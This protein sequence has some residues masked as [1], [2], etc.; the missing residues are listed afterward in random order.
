MR[1]TSWLSAFAK[2]IARRNVRM[3]PQ[4]RHCSSIRANLEQLEDRTLLSYNA[5][6]TNVA[7]TVVTFVGNS[8]GDTLTFTNNGAGLLQHNRFAEGDAGFNSAIDLDPNVGGDQTISIST[9]TSLVVQAGNGADTIQLNGLNLSSASVNLDGGGDNNDAIDVITAAV[10]IGGSAT[11]TGA[12]TID[13]NAALTAASL[14]MNATGNIAQTNAISVSGT[15]NITGATITLTQAN[16]LGAVT[17]NNGTGNVSLTEND[18]ISVA[19][20]THSG[21]VT[22]NAGTNA[23]TQTGAIEVGTGSLILTG[24]AITLADANNTVG[25]ITVNSGSGD[26]SLREDAAMSI[27]GITRT[28]G[29]IIL[30]AG[31]TLSQNGAIS[32]GTGTASLSGTTITLTQANV[33][34]AVT[35]NAGTGDVFL[36]ENA[37]ISLASVT[38][39]GNLTL[40]AG[41]NAI[42]QTGAIN[43]GTGTAN[44]TGGTITLTQAN[45]LGTVTI[46]AGS[47]NV[48]L[49]ENDAISLAAITHTGTLTLNAGT[50]GIT[51]TG[52]IG[53]GTGA[54]SL[55]GGVITL[56]DAAN[57]FG[58]I[59][60]ASGSGD[61]S[62]R[63]DAAM[64]VTGITRT[65]G[66]LTLN[67]NGGSSDLT[68]TGAISIATGTA[69][70]TA[71]NI[72]LSDAAN[73]F[74]AVRVIS[75][76]NVTLVNS[77]ATDI[78]T[79]TSTI[80]GT[81]NITSGGTLTDT[82][83]LVVTGTT[84]LSAGSG[85]DITLNNTSNNFS[86][87]V[88]NSGNNVT[89]RDTNALIVGTSTISGD[90]SVTTSGAITQ[91]G[92]IT[93]NVVGKTATFAAGAGN[94]ITL[95]N[96]SNEF[97]KVVITS[98]N[99]VSLR[100]DT[101]F[102]MGAAT[103]AGT[104]TLQSNG[105]I[106]QSGAFGST[107][108][109]VKL[110]SGTLTLS[111]TNTYSGTTTIT[112]GTLAL[113][114]ASN[115][116]IANTTSIDVG[117]GTI[118][119][120]T[121]LPSDRF[122]MASGQTLTGTGT[123]NGQLQPMS[124]SS[125]SPNGGAA[126]G[127]LNLSNG[128][129]TA[130]S[131]QSGSTFAVQVNGNVAGTSHD[132]LNVTG[133]VSLG[134][135]TLSTSGTVSSV[136][137]QVI[138]LIS[139]DGTDAVTGTFN[140]LAEGATVTIN[141][142]PFIISYAGGVGGNDVVL[143]QAGTATY[144]GT[145]VADTLELREATIAGQDFIQYY[146]G[147]VLTDQRL[148]ATVSAIQVDGGDGNDTLTLNYGGSG[149]FFSKA[150]TFNGQ[151]Q[152]STPGDALVISG[153]TFTTITNTLTSAND[154]TINLDG[155]LVTYTG[156]EPVL[157]NVGSAA[158]IVF[159]FPGAGNTAFLED[160][161]VAN[162]LSQLRSSP[163][164][165][166]TTTFV[167][168]TVSLTINMGAGADSLTITS[169][170]D[171]NASL[172]VDGGNATDSI[173]LSNN[174]TLGSATSNGNLS[175]T[176]ETIN[177]GASINTAAG[178]TGTHGNVTLSGSTAI[179]ATTGV[180]IDTNGAGTAGTLT[181]TGPISAAGQMLTLDV[182]SANNA[183]LNNAGNNFGTV[184]VTT[185][186]NVTLRDTNSIDLG[187]S[188]ISGTLSVTASGTITDS[189][190]VSVTGN[191]T[192]AAGAG[193]ITLGSGG[194]TTNY[195]SLTF[196]TTG[197]VTIQEDSQTDLSGTLTANSLTLTSSAAIVDAPGTSLTVTNGA[198]LT[199]TSIILANNG[200]DVLSV[201][202]TANFNGGA[203]DITIAGAGTVNLGNLT[204]NTTGGAVSV[205]EDSATV[206]TGTSTADSLTL[207]STGSIT[208]AVGTSIT[209]DAGAA[210]LT[211]TSISLAD[212]GT[213]VLSV[214][215]TGSFNGGAGAVTIAAAGT[216][217]FGSLT[218]N[219]TGGAV[220]IT[221]DDSTLLTGSSTGDSLTL[222]SAAGVTDANGTSVV[223]DNGTA[224]ITGTSISL[225][226]NG[227][228][229]LSVTGTASFNGGAGAIT[230]AAAGAVNF[231]SL[232]F[233]TTGGAVSIT[234]DSGTQLTG[235]S[236]GDTLTLVSSGA[237][238]DAGSTSVTIDNGAAS[239]TGTSISLADSAGDV[240]SVSGT[241]TFSGGAG[242]ITVAA[243]GTVNF[244]SLVFNSSASAVSITEDSAMTVSG[245]STAGAG[246]T[247][248]STDDVT[249]N[250]TVGVTGATSITAGTT[251]G[252]ID[253]NAKLTGSTTILLDAADEITIDAAID[254]TTVTL[255]AD[256]DI[257]INAA[258]T[259]T[260]QIS[261]QAGLDGSGG[262]SVTATGSLVTSAGGSDI[263]IT[264]GATS[265][266]IA[267]ASTVTAVDRLTLTSNAASGSGGGATQTAGTVTAANL[268]VTGTSGAF[269]LTQATNDFGTVAASLNGGSINITELN[270]II[271]GTVAT[272]GIDTGTSVNGGA[273][274]INATSGTITVNN[275]I[276]TSTGTGGALLITGS[277]IVNAAITAAGGN[278]TLN[279]STAA[280]SD[281]DINAALVSSTTLDLTAPRDILVGAL[282][283]T[284]G[285]GAD[286]ILTADSDANGV[287]GVRVETAGQILSADQVTLSGSDLFVSGGAVDSVEI[288]ADGAAVQVQGAGTISLTSGAAAPATA[289][290]IVDGLINAT[291]TATVSI[292]AD[293]DVTFAATGDITTA[294]GL[295]SVTADNATAGNTGGVI[296]QAN[297]AVINA[298]SG[299]ITLLADGNITLG[300]VS[301]TNATTTA[302]TITTTSGG[303]VDG[304]D[305]DVDIVANSGRAVVTAV[306]G[307]GS[308]N[309][310]ETTLGSLDASV[311]AAGNIS[312]AETDAITLFDVDTANGSITVTAGG[313]ITATDVAS[314]TDANANDINLT[315]TAGSI[316]VALVNAGTTLGDVFLNAAAAIDESGADG[317]ADIIGDDLRL[318]AVSGIGTAGK[319]EING[320][321]LAATTA[322]GDISLND[323]TG[324]LVITTITTVGVSIT[325]GA[326]G[327]N[328]DI[329][330]SSP[331]T[332]NS[333]VSNNGGG[334]IT[335]AANGSAATDDLTINANVT[336]SGGNGDIF[337]YAGDSISLS[338]A[339]D[340]TATGT[341][342]VLLSAGTD[343]N[344]GGGLLNGTNAGSITMTSGSTAQSEDGDVTLVAPG[345]VL[346]SLANANSDGG[347]SGNVV[348]T[349]D[350]AGV[351]GGLS[352]NAGAITDNLVAETENIIA[353]QATLTAATGIGSTASLATDIDTTI[354]T[355]V[356]TNSTSGDIVIR[357]T[358]TLTVGGTGVRT[359]G[360]NGNINLFV[361][362]GSL[363][364]TGVLTTNGTGDARLVV[365]GSVTQT[366]AGVITADQ[367]GIRAGGNVSLFPAATNDVNDLAI[368]TNGQ[369][370]FR[371]QDDL[372]V[373]TV[374]A[375][376]TGAFTSTS[377]ITSTS[378]D[379][380]LETNGAGG[381]LTINQAINAGAADLRLEASAEVTQTAA[382]T[383]SGL[384]LTDTGP[385]TLTLTTNSVSRLAANANSTINYVNAGSLIIGSVTVNTAN[386]ASTIAGITTSSDD[387]RLRV[388][389]GAFT[390]TNNINLNSGGAGGAGGDLELTATTGASQT[391]SIKAFGLALR[392]T[393]ASLNTNRYILTNDTVA[394]A[395]DVARIAGLMT[396]GH[397]EYIDLNNLDVDD[398]T[399]TTGTAAPITVTTTGIAVGNPGGSNDF[400][401]DAPGVTGGD[402]RLR[403]GITFANAILT[404]NSNLVVTV[405]NPISTTSGTGG[406]LLVGGGVELNA[407]I[408]LGSGDVDLAGSAPD[409]CIDTATV[410]TLA[411]PDSTAT[412]QP[413]GN[414]IVMEP[415]STIG[416]DL[417]LNADVDNDGTGGIWVRDNGSIDADG[418][419]FMYGTEITAAPA[420]GTA[421]I[422]TVG[423]Q[424]DDT[425][426][427]TE[428]NANTS[429]V[430]ET[431]TINGTSG[432]EDDVILTG[433]I[434]SDGT[435]PISIAAENRIVQNSTSSV[436][437]TSAGNIY[438]Q[439][440]DMV[441]DTVSAIINAQAAGIVHLR[442]RSAGL[443]INVGSAASTASGVVATTLSISNPELNRIST[444]SAVRIGF[445]SAFASSPNSPNVLTV[446]GNAGTITVSEPNIDVANSTI[447]HLI[448]GADIVDDGT[449]G[450]GTITETNL[451]LEAVTG[452]DL[453]NVNASPG[454]SG[455]DVDNLAVRLTGA[456]VNNDG[457]FK[458]RD[459]VNFAVIDGVIGANAVDV[460]QDFTL[461]AGGAVTQTAAIVTGGLELIDLFNDPIPPVTFL[462]FPDWYLPHSSNQIGRL[463]A[464]TQ[465]GVNITNSV[466]LSVETVTNF[467][468]VF[469]TS[470][471]EGVW[472][473][474]LQLVAPTVVV[475]DPIETNDEL[476][477]VTFDVTTLLDINA[478]IFSR[479]KIEQ[480]GTGL[481]TIADVEL[482]TTDDNITFLGGVTLDGAV[483]APDTTMSTDA[484]W[485]TPF[486]GIPQ[487]ADA[488][489]QSGGGSIIFSST[490]RSGPS[491]DTAAAYLGNDLDLEAGTGDIEFN[492]QVGG[493]GTHPVTLAVTGRLGI[494]N[495]IDVHSVT[496]A[497]G[498]SANAFYQQAGDGETEFNG[499]VQTNR[500]NATNGNG[501]DITTKM[502]T[503]NAGMTTTSAPGSG[504]TAAIRI[505]NSGTFSITA[506]AGSINSD[507]PVSQVG[508]GDNLVG[509][510]IVTTN[511]NISFAS[512]TYLSGT[513]LQ[514][515][516]GTGA[517]VSFAARFQ[518]NNKT[519]TIRDKDF[520]ELGTVTAIAGG[521]LNVFVNTTATRGS[522]QVGSGELLTGTG[523]LNTDVA[524]LTGGTLAPA[525]DASGLG[526]GILTI[527]GNTTLGANAVYNVDLNG[528]VAGS[529]YDQVLPGAGF[530]FTPNA[531][532]I[533]SANRPVTFNPATGT[534][535]RIVDGNV[536]MVGTFS[537]AANGSFIYVNGLYF[538]A[539]YNVATGDL[540]LTRQDPA[541][542]TS[543]I[544]DDNGGT[545]GPIAAGGSF[546]VNPNTTAAWSPN[547]VA[548]RGYGSDLR[549]SSPGT[550]TATWTFTGL[551]NGD[552]R[553]ST[554]WFAHANRATNA[555]FTV[556]GGVGTPSANL[557][558][559]NS[560]NDFTADSA[561]WEDIVTTYTVNA[562]TLT[563]TLSATGADGYV[564]ADAVRIA[565]ISVSAPEIQVTQGA[566]EITDNTAVVDWGTIAQSSGNV[567]KVFTVTNT[568]LSPL[569]LSSATITPPTGFAVIGYAP[570]S[571]AAGG[572]FN[573]TLR[574]L[575]SN[576]GNFDGQISFATNDADENPFNFRIKGAVLPSDT[577]IADN[578]TN[579][580]PKG[581][582]NT[583]TPAVSVGTGMTYV[584][585]G[586]WHDNDDS[587][588]GFQQDLRYAAANTA[589]TATWTF[590]GL[591]AG[592]Y[593]VSVTYRAEPNRASNAS[594]TVD[595]GAGGLAAVTTTINQ[596]VMPNQ[597]SDANV[598]WT[599]LVASFG[600]VT[601]GTI[602]VVLDALGSNGFVIADAIRI[603]RTGPLQAAQGPAAET[604]STV[605]TTAELDATA[606]AAIA[607][608]QAANLT[609]E[610]QAALSDIVFA[611]TD[612]PDGYLGGETQATIFVDPNAAGYGWYID[613]TPYDDAEF[614]LTIAGTEL[615]ATD[616]LAA[617]RI[618]LL[619]V[620]MHEIG[621][622]LG[623]ED[624]NPA[625]DAHNLMT[626]TIDVGTR[627][628]V[629]PVSIPEDTVDGADCSTELSDPTFDGLNDE[630]FYTLSDCG[631]NVVPTNFA[632]SDQQPESGTDGKRSGKGEGRTS[633]HGALH[634]L[635]KLIR[636][637]RKS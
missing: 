246:L 15:V 72:T 481:V 119:D 564:I 625:D 2:S 346:L 572:T 50:N 563:V 400:G 193:A 216:V 602:T 57:T 468:R 452:I 348:V 374:A 93:A 190:N 398:V 35:I 551:P 439:A 463:T 231:T 99:A 90:F 403:A 456:G 199:G 479:G 266:G 56:A 106:T 349:A 167:N 520:V 219:T 208:D 84:T 467:F 486:T 424:I 321:N 414:I 345:N 471:S 46:N 304:G 444:V 296:T 405:A 326:V 611:I 351:G 81:L 475:N 590:T 542:P 318:V 419:L 52:T 546:T 554:T 188:T 462:A 541:T 142:I 251:T 368:T 505:N 34:G 447:L 409:I 442:N 272:T 82:G 449:A 4:A 146:I 77:T 523:T 587:L 262:V 243:T 89:L 1:L 569:I 265:G 511:D 528:L 379:I 584:E 110:G 125:V 394:T 150:V 64:S 317:T 571:I 411:P 222:V 391:G 464:Y 278:V 518:I 496:A 133:Q 237:I 469:P 295:V 596:R 592:T 109:L 214:S 179:N 192:F 86:T 338:A 23:I 225:S 631:N 406:D 291:G 347:T 196:T 492:G 95:T 583:I 232:T 615:Q 529:S 445:N 342:E 154:G 254:P 5:A 17:I 104:F 212:D 313:T 238:T 32:I 76:N 378:N 66:N 26:V 550:N 147:G 53:V 497:T 457:A 122:D 621:H 160:D 360:G 453:D 474:S 206:L 13:I 63:Q 289:D 422:P 202:G 149:G 113:S 555:L 527:N 502:V 44:L 606:A 175:F 305:T 582:Y 499:F 174:I 96:S 152:T 525:M 59:T 491:G 301:T 322:T 536:A 498:F 539:D 74:G 333:P 428:I 298:G 560:P 39:T 18:A 323:T 283:Q 440:N 197:A 588:V 121:G 340:V 171:F 315:T 519:V 399:V 622:R 510:D 107:A 83:N 478:N 552:Y 330:T 557:N 630:V 581:V 213:D 307:I 273:V 553:V 418:A 567:D 579:P 114:N 169:L 617:S 341:G 543:Y 217:T 186:N 362:T 585:T 427:G 613:A 10:T 515:N 383:A 131:F 336:A 490:L 91:S 466:T 71:A 618:D 446:A 164:S 112:S 535:L 516:S 522:V 226:D 143:I 487:A 276:D 508:T 344:N 124:G 408:N 201:G 132:Q 155:T 425:T 22:L 532:A 601:S 473:Q 223:I 9:I 395:N 388:V 297:G 294:G 575:D 195:G 176:A 382:I 361:D 11:F 200:G 434:H 359:L 314:T 363:S 16:V 547:S 139:N 308:A 545:A 105:A 576:A 509:G 402:V 302:V 24:G 165:F 244:G 181:V 27:A 482:R 356:A 598:Y 612:L 253:V 187:A 591:A 620:L 97:T 172:T 248:V 184:V 88:I 126:T 51:Q 365:A 252:G 228:D 370:E 417:T 393:G 30:I 366:A 537:N 372:N 151:G 566:T 102:D 116:N 80:S 385:F 426:A 325:G 597:F 3:H 21:D 373:T 287:G 495:I 524:I 404:A 250:A 177:L 282:V 401:V 337:L 512:D 38:H 578:P 364:F 245:A 170:P 45:V 284:T 614:G 423:I 271:V 215:G 6:G 506:G 204:F 198:S 609:A 12:E 415:L 549:F 161:G 489:A 249:L 354:T 37:A 300:S 240:L 274:T 220:S 544:I 483:A 357:E 605:L 600:S 288:Q 168:P 260:T 513:P 239:F 485:T 412:L 387:V 312:I 230:I 8:T 75:G 178:T 117:A 392:G 603:E 136:P 534:V 607:R 332:V 103:V 355:L 70:L 381:T 420:C 604:T 316:L 33:L 334:D 263:D 413:I 384:L 129:S 331:L 320:V 367:L 477:F 209:V 140:G 134:N 369:V 561:N 157:I 577:K 54:L 127:I 530:T 40:N 68:Q 256:D 589:A 247:L 148:S 343:Y 507:G 92:V 163:V 277:V 488:P 493:A 455:N 438:Y 375:D 396:N 257:T 191:A 632:T 25:L 183:T 416:G 451:A 115:N 454:V 118:F 275:V 436:S 98:G 153:G 211:G 259:A 73:T 189:G 435:G 7:G 290:I 353:D 623:L 397:I 470:G 78:A 101:G 218:F 128:A 430:I 100:D 568:G 19:A 180:T 43:V 79:G 565:P 329:S 173:T 205:T 286:V 166:E 130:V 501:I 48:S 458:D 371:D 29:D 292:T 69:I 637:G 241:A 233:N 94:N 123:V 145:P 635:L 500:G 574:L 141:S 14:V 311:T 538:R 58:A 207:V 303:V 389:T 227:G 310:I 390:I 634:A 562:G 264:T 67:A 514:I 182:G 328:I 429:I 533:L 465:R 229:T 242:A 31:T 629:V 41:T 159:N 137:S 472:A 224:S 593:R 352:D 558:Q 120:V 570:T 627:R 380:Y 234:E 60:V 267:L 521:V 324:G 450:D 595:D 433:D 531:A 85:N 377:G 548:G 49:T 526:T 210:S 55:T 203:G 432:N 47:G 138:I 628:L 626:D 624:I 221:E 556:S 461:I 459:D 235:T 42:T 407:A 108:S 616:P 599:D 285:A 573:F 594:F 270:S 162:T 517:D 261:V 281:L 443:P 441:I 448:T 194:E 309:A 268:Q 293:Q 358:N 437:L 376:P 87:I 255:Q 476:G 306:T 619:T 20:I 135:A 279:G 335:L 350:Y 608:W 460:V 36:T 386:T 559:R 280:A 610:Q 319:I 111:Q 144:I 28:S 504:A 269:S 480:I 431:K 633:G 494:V 158:N 339:T 62:L 636:R 299:T 327:D 156:L 586:N 410:I 61:V 540:T 503:L 65:S 484:N 185:A 580:S 236:T 421:A 258:V